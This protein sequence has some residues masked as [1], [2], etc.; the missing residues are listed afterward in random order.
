MS[1]KTNEMKNNFLLFLLL[2]SSISCTTNRPE[3]QLDSQNHLTMATLWYQRSAE[4]RA[5][6]YQAFNLARIVVD[7]NLSLSDTGQKAVVLDIDET[8]L[9]NS[10]F[11][12]EM[13]Q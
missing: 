7:Q 8:V 10:P 12:A 4:M 9:D 11:Q 2:F 5:L 6:Y 1:D 13:I 3:S